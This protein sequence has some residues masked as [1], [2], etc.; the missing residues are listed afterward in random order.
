MPLDGEGGASAE[1]QGLRRDVAAALFERV[2]AGGADRETLAEGGDLT[3]ALAGVLSGVDAN[4]AGRVVAELAL[5]STAVR[6]DAEA[7]L[8]FV[9]AVGQSQQRAP[10]HLVR[11]VLSASDVTAS[12][13]RPTAQGL[14]PRIAGSFWQA[15][16]WR[17]VA[18]CVVALFAAAGSL[19]LY[20]KDADRIESPPAS[21]AKTDDAADRL[22]VANARA[23]APDPVA[24]QGCEMS[25]Q[26]ADAVKEASNLRPG[27]EKE[28]GG[29]AGNCGTPSVDTA[30]SEARA[31]AEM[32]RQK[33]EVEARQAAAR[34]DAAKMRPA[35]TGRRPAQ[36]DQ[37][38]WTLDATRPSAKALSASPA[39]PAAPPP[40][41]LPR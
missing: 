38:D 19:S 24:T 31:R 32:E 27:A 25:S 16:R 22:G 35:R 10:A 30:L 1:L 33:A 40:A 21:V 28:S 17:V 20:W 41:A 15:R 7:A 4:E 5:R 11:D 12:R 36:A 23:T 26:A 29:S 2:R 8:A 14:L 13:A 39:I 18:A 34:A 9:D 37:S 6:L 3:A